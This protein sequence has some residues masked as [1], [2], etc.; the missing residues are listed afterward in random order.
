MGLDPAPSVYL[1]RPCYLGRA[2][3]PGC[4]PWYWTHGRYPADPE[5]WFAK[6]KQ[7]E[8]SWWTDWGA[9]LAKK[10]GKKVPARQP[11]DGKLEPIEDAPGSYVKVRAPD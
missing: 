2:A 11:G 6:A 9:W 10:G 1:G 7:H 5:A 4:H 8:G 3:D